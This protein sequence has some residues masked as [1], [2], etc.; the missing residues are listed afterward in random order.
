MNDEDLTD[1]FAGMAMQGML[2]ARCD[3]RDHEIA[4]LSYNLA[5]AMVEEKRVRKTTQTEP[6]VGIA[7]IK[8]KYVRKEKL[9]EE[10]V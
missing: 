1:L 8:R 6:D 7:A 2:A 3:E 10:A 4:R 9:N 5:Q